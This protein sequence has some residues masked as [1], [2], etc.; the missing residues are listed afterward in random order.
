MW[1]LC[2]RVHSI[3]YCILENTIITC[4]TIIFIVEWFTEYT[5]YSTKEWS[6]GF[7]VEDYHLFFYYLEL[8]SRCEVEDNRRWVSFI[9]PLI[10]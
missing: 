2:K 3:H 8:G 7:L 4:T 9:A 5:Q 1:Q 10:N 6:I